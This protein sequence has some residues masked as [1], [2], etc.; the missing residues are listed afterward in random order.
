MLPF[1]GELH[2]AQPVAAVLG[3]G[4]RDFLAGYAEGGRVHDGVV[5]R[6]PLVVRKRQEPF[7][8]LPK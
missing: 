6:G 8:K 5:E 7:A 1:L 2:V 4:Q 3:P